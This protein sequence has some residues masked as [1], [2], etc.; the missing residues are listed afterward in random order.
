MTAMAAVMPI[1]G[2][3]MLVAPLL[4]KAVRSTRLAFAAV[5][6][7]R[8]DCDKTTI[9]ALLRDTTAAVRPIRI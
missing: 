5:Y 7:R 1:K 8:P 4:F 3:L 6:S 2:Y 9:A